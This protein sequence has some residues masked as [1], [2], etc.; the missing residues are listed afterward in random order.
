MTR[1]FLHGLERTASASVE[2]DGEEPLHGQVDRP[3]LRWPQRLL[4]RGDDGVAEFR[5]VLAEDHV[6]A[7]ESRRA[8][9]RAVAR[10][11]HGLRDDVG[12]VA[13]AEVDDEGRPRIHR[14]RFLL[15][16][17]EAERDI[18]E[19]LLPRRFGQAFAQQDEA[20]VRLHRGN[21]VEAEQADLRPQGVQVDVHRFGERDGYGQVVRRIE[22][23]QLG[24]AEAELQALNQGP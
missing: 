6:A 9:G 14:D 23:G 21:L 10:V 15:E 20:P 19:H 8:R 17:A 7:E 4:D 22:R 24:G 12:A 16:L 11:G 5:R 18:V 13:R 2:P 1:R 3:G